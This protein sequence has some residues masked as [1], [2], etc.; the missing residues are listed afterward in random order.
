MINKLNDTYIFSSF[1]PFDEILIFPSI[2]ILKPFIKFIGYESPIVGFISLFA[3]A[4]V[5]YFIYQ[6]NKGITWL[7]IFIGFFLKFIDGLFMKKYKNMTIE[8]YEFIMLLIKILSFIIVFAF[9]E[10]SSLT[11][12]NEFKYYLWFIIFMTIVL[13][14]TEYNLKKVVKK[15]NAIKHIGIIIL[16]ITIYTLIKIK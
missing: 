5:F 9:I 8:N 15:E 11:D 13:L 1:R 6:K 12:I 3:I 7:F 14:L 10:S 16:F 4:C 2:K